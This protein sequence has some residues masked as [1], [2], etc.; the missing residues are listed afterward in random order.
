[1]AKLINITMTS[2]QPVEEI[3]GKLFDGVEPSVAARAVTGL[4]ALGSMARQNSNSPGLLPC[5]VH[6]FYRGLAGLWVCMDPDCTELPP[7]PEGRERPAGKLFSQPRDMCECGARVL[8]LFTCR[9]CGTAYG[10][11]YTDNLEF[12]DYLW[13]EPGGE[14]RT[15]TKQYDELSQIDLLLEEPNQAYGTSV[16][17]A[18]YDLAT[19]R[20][21]PQH[22]GSRNRQVYI[23]ADRASHTDAGEERIGPGEFKPCAVCGGTAAFGRSSVQDHQTKGDEPFQAL[24]SKQINVQPPGRPPTRIAPLRGRKVLVFSDSRQVA[25]RLAPNLQMYSARDALRPLMVA[26]YKELA[27]SETLS[28]DLSLE[29]LYL[30]VLIAAKGMGVRIRPELKVGEVF[31]AENIVEEAVRDGALQDDT[32]LLR[33]YRRIMRQTPPESLLQAIA[34][35]LKDQYYGLEALALASIV[36]RSEHSSLIESLPDIPGYAETSDEKL[37]LARVWLRYWKPL[38]IWFDRMPLS[39]ISR[40][41]RTHT[42]KF[43]AMSRI[44]RDPRAKRQFERDWVA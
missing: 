36:E 15:L 39:W 10:R 19:G 29:D 7:I 34:V 18:E 6:A 4:V 5:R 8:E 24:V 12:P 20:L 2:A 14:F 11:A 38:G 30:A 16:E 1:M 35:S 41:I 27:D 25:A 37:A 33:L 31:E 23:R 26:G 40:V 3:G 9:N 28:E 17:P 43:N 21:N 44:L 13:S 32:K 42:G 22:L